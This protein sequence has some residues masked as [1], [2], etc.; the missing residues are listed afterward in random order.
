MKFSVFHKIETDFWDTDPD[1]VNFP[2][3]FEEVAT[4]DTADINGVFRLTNHIDCEWWNN[5][6][7]T[8]VKESRSTSVGDVV[9]D[10]EGNRFLCDKIGWSKF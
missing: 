7:V 8:L 3:G 10:A 1:P 2:K 4:V 9:V 5:V 6:E